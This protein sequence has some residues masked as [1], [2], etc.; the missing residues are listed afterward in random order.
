MAKAARSDVLK[1]SCPTADDNTCAIERT[2]VTGRSGSRL[3]TLAF[4]GSASDRGS[5]AVWTTRVVLWNH[6]TGFWV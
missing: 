3:Q 2:W 4:T 6:A 5:V 1:R